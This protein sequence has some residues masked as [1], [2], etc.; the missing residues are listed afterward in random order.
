ME[1][2][3]GV[4][5]IG[6]DAGGQV[7]CFLVDDGRRLTLIDTLWDGDGGRI[8][9]EIRR[10][11]RKVTDL[12]HI[13]LT[14]AHRSHLGGLA[15]LKAA[16][17]ATVLCHGWESDIV[18]GDRVAQPVPLLPMRPVRAYFHVY[19]LQLGAALGVGKHR[20]CRVD[21]LLGDGD[22]V[23]P[24][25]V[26]HAP[27][28]TPGH[29]AF[30]LPEQRVLFVGDAVVTYPLFSAGWPAFVLNHRQA[31]DSLVRFAELRPD[32]AAVGHGDAVRDGT[33][34]RLEALTET[35]YDQWHATRQPTQPAT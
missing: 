28:H 19:P 32:V 9:E 33:A 7:R 24:L 20:P 29:L 25:Q 4:Y 11:G 15:A 30:H 3:R 27:G 10:I 8:L 34:E 18:E 16:S 14:H 22:R 2:A 23:G 26:I 31:Y 35:A 13:V 6:Q 12:Q 17:G 21:G 1:I 5:S